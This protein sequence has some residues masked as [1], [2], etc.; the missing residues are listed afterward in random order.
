MMFG[1]TMIVIFYEVRRGQ[2]GLEHLKLLDFQMVEDGTFEFK[3]LKKFRSETD[4]NHAS[5]GTNVACSGVIPFVDIILD[6][7]ITVF[8]P[9]EFFAFYRSLVPIG[10]TK[11]GCAG[12]FLFH[13]K[14]ST[15]CKML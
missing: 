12:G 1:A 15:K 3:Y 6:D 10:S 14:F 7:G 2:E 11:E 5:R 13:R 9:G 4:K 8:N